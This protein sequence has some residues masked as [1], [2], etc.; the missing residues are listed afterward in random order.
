MTSPADAAAVVAGVEAFDL[1]PFLIAPSGGKVGEL[2]VA[3]TYATARSFEFDA[4]VVLGA[5]PGAD[6]LP[7]LDARAAQ[8]SLQPAAPPMRGSASSSARCGDTARQWSPLGTPGGRPWMPSGSLRPES[9]SSPPMTPPCR[10]CPGRAGRAPG[11]PPGV[12]PLDPHERLTPA[13]V[14]PVPSGEGTG[15]ACAQH[16][17]A[18]RDLAFDGLAHT[19]PSGMKDVW[20]RS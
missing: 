5:A 20:N 11:P 10:R 9:A 18:G 2:V 6:A 17:P 15:L 4:L 19:R 7:S 16:V 14:S 8:P 13:R 12:G 1:L 3:R